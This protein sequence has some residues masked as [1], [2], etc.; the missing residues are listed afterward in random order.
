LY[1]EI[2]QVQQVI[3]GEIQ[4]AMEAFSVCVHD[5]PCVTLAVFRQ[6]YHSTSNG[7]K[8]I[9]SSFS[10]SPGVGGGD[11]G[12]GLVLIMLSSSGIMYFALHFI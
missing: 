2:H 4:L 3:A 8:P 9:A 7:L 6:C 12:V 10:T 5:D 11:G 1:Y